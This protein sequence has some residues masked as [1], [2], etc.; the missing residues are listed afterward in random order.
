MTKKITIK[1]LSIIYLVVMVLA[2]IYCKPSIKLFGGTLVTS[3]WI[4]LF[5]YG[6]LLIEKITIILGTNP[7][8]WDE[9]SN[10]YKKAPYLVTGGFA[11][12]FLESAIALILTRNFAHA[13]GF[14]PVIVSIHVNDKIQKMYDAN[15]KK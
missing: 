10:L 6:V 8:T 13:S 11:L 7:I 14:L 1:I 12:F 2:C 4:S 9:Q 5:S 3:L 15:K